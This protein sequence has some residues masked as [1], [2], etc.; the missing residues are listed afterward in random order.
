MFS[1]SEGLVTLKILSI[2]LILRVLVSPSSAFE[3]VSTM[4]MVKN[5]KP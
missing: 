1:V 4:T 3:N 5:E 2:F